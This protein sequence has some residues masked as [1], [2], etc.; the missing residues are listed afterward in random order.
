MKAGSSCVPESAGIAVYCTW[1]P[2]VSTS[3]KLSLC[4]QARMA[5]QLPW[6][7]LAGGFPA[8]A[9]LAQLGDG[10][11]EVQAA[12]D[13]QAASQARQTLNRHCCRVLIG[14]LTR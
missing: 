14:Y 12:L 11:P 8:M 5:L 2:Y 4:L 7:T 1:A 10:A 9:A 6:W 3:G 13:R